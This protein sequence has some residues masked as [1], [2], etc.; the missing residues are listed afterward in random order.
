M[1][2]KIIS[3]RRKIK[4]KMSNLSK[5]GKLAKVFTVLTSTATVL[6]LS[7]VVY[8]APVA[9]LAVAPADYGLKEG[10]VVSAAGSDDPDVYIVN[11]MGYKRLFL[12]PAIF[13]FYGHLGGFAAVKNV[14]AA[15]RDAFGT[16]GLFRNCESNDPK[17]YGVETT[18]EDTGMLHWVNTSGAQAVADDPNF[19]SKV[20][21]INNNE[22]NWYSKGADYTSVSQVPNYSRGG[23][24]VQAGP[25]SVGLASSNPVAGSIVDT[26][27]RYTLA[28]FM[29]SGSATVTAFKLKR[30]GVSAD[31]SLKNVYL[32]DGNRRL[33]DS[34][35]VSDG[36]MNFNDASGLFTVS[37]SK[38]ISVVAEVDGSAG[39]TLGVQATEV[40]GNAVSVSSNLHTIATATLATYTVGSSTP[41]SDGAPVPQEDF[42]AW[43]NTTTVAT[44]YVWLKSLQM[45]VVGSVAVGDLRNFRL[46]VDGVQVGSALAQ[47]G[48]DGYVLFDMSGSPVK[49]ETGS[50][51]LKVLVDIIGG[52]SKNFYLSLRQKPDVW[53]VDSQY[54]A[55]VPTAGTLP[56]SSTAQNI[57]SGTLTVTKTNDSP[58]G[59]VVKDASGVVLARYEFKAAGESMKVENLLIA[60]ESTGSEF[61]LRNAAIFADGVQVGS[62]TTLWEVDSPTASS[63]AG[64]AEVSLGSS[65]IVVPGTPRILEIRADIF[66]ASGTNGIVAAA[67]ITAEFT[68]GAS[69]VQR[70]V[71][72]D[73]VNGPGAD[74]TGNTL[75]VRTGSLT[76]GKY[77]GYANQ[78]IVDPKNGVKVG[79]FTFTAASSENVNVTSLDFMP[80]LVTGT[81]FD[82]GQLLDAYI[83]VWNDAGGVV[84]TSPAKSAALSE[85]ASTSFSV[86]FT[87][88]KNKTYQVEVWANVDSG[89]TDDDAVEL[90][91]SATGTTVGSSTSSTTS[92]V[93]G[94]TITAA[95]GAFTVAN[96]SIAVSNFVNGGVTK[97]VYNFTITPTY[98]DYYLEEIYVDIASPTVASNSG[99]VAN[100]L[101]KDGSTTLATAAVSTTTGSASFT[102]LNLSLPQASG[103]KTLSLDVQF[104]N[105]GVGA[106]DTGGNVTLY[107]DGYKYRN[108]A[109]T[110]TT[111]DGLATATY[112]ANA[113]RLVKGY[114][115][116]TAFALPTTVLSGGTQ[117]LFKTTLSATGGQIAWNE[118]AFTVAS[119]SD[120]ITIAS[121]TYQLWENG[122]NITPSSV[123][124]TASDSYSGTDDKIAF[125]FATERVVSAGSSVTLELRA[126]ITGALVAGNSISTK[127]ANP[128]G[129]TVTSE[130]S[131]VQQAKPA[132]FVWTDQ[133]APSHSTSTDDWFTDG[134][135]K[136]LVD[137][138]ILIK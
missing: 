101:L 34:V 65:L 21:C 124:A 23:Q 13:N 73:Y 38:V 92:V 102:G 84:Y 31:A 57:A 112:A 58:S 39:E 111:T 51:T 114:P 107:L 56:A 130:D 86:N 8:L 4:I 83:K 5:Q 79:H 78:S 131:T 50:R 120:V 81:T 37:G 106:N 70:L 10:D 75:T 121:S 28:D 115:V 89:L 69:N 9:A 44:R 87:L 29:F 24:Q 118:I 43:Q 6:S 61:A 71:T 53:V 46:F 14:S 134:L 60:N 97:N 105:V 47:Q 132:S 128:T 76:A 88:P 62:T 63:S 15:T 109:G 2:D 117:T 49:L 26:Q 74:K 52:S 7:G 27:A 16:S 77:S 72:L 108:S 136:T 19:F 104:S 95:A 32:Y 1:V 41:S 67:E 103:T 85:S 25:V 42:V 54:G 98:D 110:I 135:V 125:S 99:A 94:Q 90:A 3:G 11:E 91:F 17:V 127:I 36:V 126:T 137:T 66:D 40:N 113:Q 129:T 22:F 116:F 93:D 48:A 133:S 12:N 68:I 96:G 59:D 55:A 138:Q 122:V 30:V 82:G 119:S 80:Q 45:R 64:Y 18:G 123:G 100:L 33:T 20:F 35:T